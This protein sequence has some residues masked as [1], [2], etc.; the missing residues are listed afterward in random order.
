MPT[1]REIEICAYTN[2]LREMFITKERE[3]KCAKLIFDAQ[4]KAEAVVQFL[5]NKERK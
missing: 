4:D 2:E 3:Y 5:L 1:K